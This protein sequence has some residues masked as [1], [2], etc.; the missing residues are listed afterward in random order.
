MQSGSNRKTASILA[1]AGLLTSLAM[2]L[3][4]PSANAQSIGYVS[5]S[6]SGYG[7]N[8]GTIGWVSPGPLVPSIGGVYVGGSGFTLSSGGWVYQPTPT[9]GTTSCSPQGGTTGSTGNTAGEGGGGAVGDLLVDSGVQDVGG[10]GGGGETNND[11]PNDPHDWTGD[12]PTYPINT[13][14]INTLTVTPEPSTIV[15]L[16]S[17][18]V[19]LGGAGGRRRGQTNPPPGG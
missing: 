3:F 18:L 13:E 16:G 7:L 10:A 12:G 5:G 4:A 1:R 2:A 17:G 14:T 11:D 19:G 8:C 6:Y 15:L 9:Y